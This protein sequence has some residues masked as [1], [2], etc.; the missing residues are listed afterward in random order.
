MALKMAPTPEQVQ[1]LDLFF[2]KLLG[3]V[4]MNR[5]A[6]GDWS[7]GSQFIDERNTEVETLYV[8]TTGSDQ[9]DGSQARPVASISEALNRLPQYGNKNIT[10]NI[11]AGT[12]VEDIVLNTSMNGR[13]GLL[14]IQ[15]DPSATWLAATVATGVSSGT[16]ASV[17]A[18]TSTAGAKGTVTGAGWTV[19]NLKGVFVKVTSGAWS[20]KYIPIFRNSATE[21]EFGYAA[22]TNLNG[23]TFELVTPP[24]I[25]A[26]TVSA[27]GAAY[28]LT[29]MDAHS[30]VMLATASPVNNGTVFSGIQF[31]SA[32]TGVMGIYSSDITFVQ[33][34]INNNSG[35]GFFT[36][37]SQINMYGTY[38]TGTGAGVSNI[39]PYGYNHIE[40]REGCVTDNIYFIPKFRSMGTWILYNN[41]IGRNTLGNILSGGANCYLVLESSRLVGATVAVYQ[42]AYDTS[43]LASLGGSF[44]VVLNSGYI[45]GCSSH[46]VQLRGNHAHVRLGGT[47]S[48]ITGNG[49]FGV[50]VGDS[51]KQASFN[52]I[53]VA[54]GST[55][56]SNTS[57]DFSLDGTTAISLA[58]VTADGDKTIV[59]TARFNRVAQQ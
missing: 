39:V 46:G 56:G 14:L 26:P 12:Y 2:N 20:G 3:V 57:G 33:C 4:G 22:V 19:D 45:S 58:D 7:F 27:S 24:V 8:S 43:T 49:G 6:F 29:A 18:A 42:D 37:M 34:K 32:F 25:I 35:G 53:F 5:R 10:V 36:T 31:E 1:A 9:N 16:F 40:L 30:R 48:A 21:L 59:D 55:M 54:T 50:V 44:E 41:S 11:A 23:A 38:I 28:T 52:S 47:A 13:K 51:G 15:A 17:A